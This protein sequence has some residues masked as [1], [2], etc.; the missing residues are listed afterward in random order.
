MPSTT[1]KS[2]ALRGV[3]VKVMLPRKVDTPIL[4]PINRGY[5]TECLEAGV[6]IIE[7][8]GEFNHSKTMVS[9]NYLS[10]VGAT[11]LDVR[12]F[13]INNEVNSFIF[14]RET[15]LGIKKSF[16]ERLPGARQWTLE[17]WLASRTLKEILV[18][19]FV[20]LFYREF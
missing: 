15:A 9:D 17:S 6:Q 7:S 3:D 14:D 16:E 5:Y 20:R 19:S 2:A 4:G 1:I 11:N 8:E 10:V 13:T 18:S 12:S